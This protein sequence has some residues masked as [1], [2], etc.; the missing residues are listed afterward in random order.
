MI[1]VEWNNIDTAMLVAIVLM[2]L[3]LIVLAAAET[4]LNRIS[5]VKAQAI[6]DSSGKRSARALV[7]LVEHPERFINPLL[8]TVTFCQTGQAF[9]SHC[10]PTG[11]SGA[12]VSLVGFF[13]NVV[14]FFV[15][16]ES[17]PKTWAV[18]PAERAGLATARDHR[19]A[20][21]VPAAAP[22]L[23]GVDLAHQRAAARQG[24]QAGAVRQRAGAARHRRAAAQDDVIEHDERELIE[25]IIEFGDTV[26]REVMVPQPDMVVITDD[27]D[28]HA[29][30]RSCHRPRVQPAAGVGH[31]R[32]RRR[33]HRLHEGSDPRRARRPAE[34]IA[35][36][37][38]A[39]PFGSSPRT[40][41]CAS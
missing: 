20:R 29:G 15:V 1:A 32:R 7:R 19:V 35:V 38:L 30:A 14:V 25:S 9:L 24:P 31:Q 10:W 27:V 4:A 17:M 6:A 2:L 16:A 13:L 36:H 12:L 34:V 39:R 11:C 26:A 41:R 21:V 3:V 18:L 8:V 37:E 23:A 5:R 33:R 28:G 40:S 22:H